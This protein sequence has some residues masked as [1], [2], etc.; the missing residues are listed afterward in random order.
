[1]KSL[2]KTPGIILVIL[3]FISC[4]A[5]IDGKLTNPSAGITG[6]WQLITGTLIEKG[7]TIVTHYNKNVS[8]IKIINETH[9]AFLQHDLK[10]GQDSAAVFVAGGGRYSLTDST[11][12]EHLEY[13]SARNWEGNDF[14]FTISIKGDT[15]IQSGTEKVESAGVDRINIEKYIRVISDATS[16]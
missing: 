1:M 16:K 3:F 8:F 7:D 11:Y 15:L 4:K 6:T 2:F 14:K 12:T 5:G 9:F 10:K 13:C